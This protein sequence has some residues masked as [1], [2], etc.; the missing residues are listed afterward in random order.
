MVGAGVQKLN[1][2]ALRT[3][4]ATA[5]GTSVAT[6]N[7]AAS[8]A[9]GSIIVQQQPSQNQQQGTNHQGQQATITVSST[10]GGNPTNQAIQLV[11]T[12]Q[13]GGRNIQVM[14]PKQLAGSR[15]II[16]QRQIGGS[17]LKI[18]AANPINGE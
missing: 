17:T 7:A 1:P 2:S 11:G 14:G 4:S 10:G 18:A 3:S 9:G 6:S 13:Q 15:Q 12:I 5:S 16:T 8:A